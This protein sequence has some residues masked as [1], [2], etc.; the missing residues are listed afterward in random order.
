M[1]NATN[2]AGRQGKIVQT[3]LRRLGEPIEVAYGVLFL[4]FYEA[5]FVTGAELV[6]MVDISLTD[7]VSLRDTERRNSQNS[8]SKKAGNGPGTDT[9]NSRR[10]PPP[11]RRHHRH[12]AVGRRF[13]G[14]VDVLQNITSD[15]AMRMLN[16]NFRPGR[17]T[18]VN[19]LCYLLGGS[20]R[21]HRFGSG[22]YLLPTA[23]KLQQNF[24]ARGID[25]AAIE[26]V[27]LTHM[28][29]DHSADY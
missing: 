15:E 21:A 23:G 28:H 24:A 4:A 6:M 18:S 29:P 5:S 22:D 9:P 2:A 8:A 20:S 16:E 10:I 12:Y 13:D 7:P 27:S 26:R 1:L 3:P 19:K 17:R 25:P 11:Y 14:T